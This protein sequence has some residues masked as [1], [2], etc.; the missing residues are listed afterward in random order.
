MNKAR[1]LP[2]CLNVGFTQAKT[3]TPPMSKRF[4]I[5]VAALIPLALLIM[6][7]VAPATTVYDVVDKGDG[8]EVRHYAPYVVA[9]TTASGP[10]DTA[11][12]AAFGVLVDYIGGANEGQLHLPMTAPVNQQPQGGGAS[13]WLFQFAI[14][15]EYLRSM[16]PRPA[17]PDIKLRQVPAH[18]AAARRYRGN[19]S[20]SRYREQEHALLAALN[21]AG[22]ETVGSPMFARYNAAFVPGFLRRNEV[23]VEVKRP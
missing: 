19:W 6:A 15:P 11:D 12:D 21:Q 9:E 5:L 3:Q 14:S 23:I 20:E 7:L 13:D 16:V 1:P 10:F 17:N 8:F 18:F 4:V 22:I 2:P